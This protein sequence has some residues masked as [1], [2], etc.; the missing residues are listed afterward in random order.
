METREIDLVFAYAGSK[1][2]V[3]SIEVEG[4]TKSK[5]KVIMG[6]YLR[7]GDVFDLTR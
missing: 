6:S 2:Y 1:F 4:N 3:E 5:S 7:P